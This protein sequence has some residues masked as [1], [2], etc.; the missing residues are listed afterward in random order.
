MKSN[1][2]GKHDIFLKVKT[3]RNNESRALSRLWVTSHTSCVIIEHLKIL[4]IIA[5]IF[6]EKVIKFKQISAQFFSSHIIE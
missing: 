3:F 6:E 1:Y 4:I 5:I 2:I